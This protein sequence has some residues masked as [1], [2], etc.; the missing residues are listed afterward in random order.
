[1]D[2]EERKRPKMAGRQGFE[3]GAGLVSKLLMARDFW[4]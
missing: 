3:L 2:E 4:F 1:M